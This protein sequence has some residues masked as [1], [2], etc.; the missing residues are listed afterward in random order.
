[1]PEDR[2][3][4]ARLL[5]SLDPDIV[6]VFSSKDRRPI[7][8]LL[9]RS[10]PKYLCPS[11]IAKKIR[12]DNKTVSNSLKYIVRSS[13][14]I[15]N[16]WHLYRLQG[17]LMRPVEGRFEKVS[18]GLRLVILFLVALGVFLVFGSPNIVLPLLYLAACFAAMYNFAKRRPNVLFLI[19]AL[20]VLGGE[21]GYIGWS[22]AESR[23]SVLL[24]DISNQTSLS[25]LRIA[26]N[27][28]KARVLG[29]APKPRDLHA[30]SIGILGDSGHAASLLRT[31]GRYRGKC[32]ADLV[33]AARELE[34]L[35]S[36]NLTSL[37]VSTNNSEKRRIED[38]LIRAAY[39]VS[40]VTRPKTTWVG[41]RRLVIDP[42]VARAVRIEMEE[43]LS[44]LS[45]G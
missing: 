20:M 8:D 24:G 9:E 4:I 12:S 27:F 11:E 23:K 40:R 3:T 43:S 42:E 22:T 38:G 31:L 30:I 41:F 14:L 21:A 10:Y 44:L 7:L 28:Q 34:L 2:P 5:L 36:S 25:L 18:Y 17:E 6:R 35:R 39:A 1:V 29:Q 45:A 32:Q 13:G 37:L 15:E 16:R 26:A 33:E 19:L